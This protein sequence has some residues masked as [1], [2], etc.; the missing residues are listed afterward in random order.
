MR[1][2]P[3]LDLSCF[4]LCVICVLV[5]WLERWRHINRPIHVRVT[6]LK[7]TYDS[8]HWCVLKALELWIFQLNGMRI[9]VDY[10]WFIHL[11]IKTVKMDN[12]WSTLS[13]YLVKSSTNFIKAVGLPLSKATSPRS[14]RVWATFSASEGVLEISSTSGW[15]SLYAF[16]TFRFAVLFGMVL[17][18]AIFLFLVII[19]ALASFVFLKFAG[20][21]P[22]STFAL[23]TDSPGMATILNLETMT[24][25]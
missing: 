7:T 16:K 2:K 19:G 23:T 4:N 25:F 12:S 24:G 9:Y 21:L 11:Q 8:R 10:I 22:C 13:L 18:G 5:Q 1:K 3:T 20:A 17:E 14:N 15:R 6:H